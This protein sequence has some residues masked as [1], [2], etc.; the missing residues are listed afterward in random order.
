MANIKFSQLPNLS[1]ANIVAGTYA[2]VV[3]AFTNYTVTMAN[4]VSYVNQNSG[5]I[6]VT[7]TVSATGNITGSY[8]LGNG[9]QLTGL[10]ATYGNAN[11]VANL[12]AL[13]TNPISTSGNV[14]AG[15]FVGN[16]STL[17][18]ITGA[19]VSGTVALAT[20]A[21]TAGTVTSNA[22]A[23]ITSVGVLTSL[24]STGNVRAGNV[25]TDNYAYANGTPINFS[26][27]Y[28]NANVSGFMAVFGSNVITT[29]GNIQAG[30]FQG[31]GSLLTGITA[32]ANNAFIT[33]NA[34]G[35]VLTAN[36]TSG[37]LNI[38]AGTNIA[39]TGTGANNNILIA[40]SG[41]VANATY[42][43]SAGSAATA[44]TAGSATTA[45]T[46][47]T[48]GTVT[49]AS[50]SAITSVGTL[51]SLSVTGNVSANYYIGNGSLLTGI[52]GGG[53]NANVTV[54]IASSFAVGTYSTGTGEIISATATIPAGTFVAG[55][56]VE[57]VGEWLTNAGG[58]YQRRLQAYINTTNAIPGTSL[59]VG[60]WLASAS[61]LG[62]TRTLTRL[63]VVAT[64]GN[65][66]GFYGGG[67]AS[68]ITFNNASGLGENG[69]GAGP[70]VFNIDWTTTQY[71]IF[72]CQRVSGAG[73]EGAACIGYQIYRR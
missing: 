40:V 69:A 2:P 67:A 70:L 51:T 56:V 48:A 6:S 50:Q 59:Q 55:D 68:S 57:I 23:N 4:L 53:S 10:P 28:S 32:S 16:A 39:V 46:A 45:T 44:T 35:T 38:T 37:V 17:S 25:L 30:Y 19:N 27:T 65:T 36:T 42:A 58:T 33:A 8:I 71:V 49:S 47:V 31:N 60:G 1:L 29:T 64:S 20:A 3:D 21:T 66:R 9:S 62:F 22:Q 63:D 11:V 26:G 73:A 43:A 18:N 15:Y 12:A 61:P 72:T 5:N 14:T 24:S 13:G 7:G 52:A 34:N 54:R 41:T